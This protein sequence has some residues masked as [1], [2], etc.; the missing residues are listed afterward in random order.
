MKLNFRQKVGT[1]PAIIET[2]IVGET[3]GKQSSSA[4]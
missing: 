3:A 2:M 4:C 1:L